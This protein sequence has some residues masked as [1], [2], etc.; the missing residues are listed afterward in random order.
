MRLGTKLKLRDAFQMVADALQE[1]IEQDAPA[2]VKN[3]T[4]QRSYSIS[5][6][7]TES[8]EGPNGPYKKATADKNQNNPD[9]EALFK[10]L[11]EH[12]GKLTKDGLFCWLFGQASQKT[13]GIKPSR[14]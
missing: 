1:D 5:K 12:N 7:N 6:I 2:E 8:A 4:E 13:L 14:L 11:E 9:F 3:A 10:D